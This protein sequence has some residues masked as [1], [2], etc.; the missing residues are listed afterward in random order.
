ME[1]KLI[2]NSVN[3]GKKLINTTLGTFSFEYPAVITYFAN[4]ILFGLKIH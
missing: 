2:Q 3:N 1:G 4:V